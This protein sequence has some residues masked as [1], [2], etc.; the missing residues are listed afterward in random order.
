MSGFLFDDFPDVSEKQWK[1]K[2]QFDLKGLDYNETLFTQTTNGISIKPFYH[3]DSYQQLNDITN[4][5]DFNICQ[6]IFVSDEK[7][8]NYIAI[9]ALKKGANTLLFKANKPFDISLLLKGIEIDTKIQFD[10]QFL[11]DNFIKDL[12]SHSS[13]Y[14]VIL[15]IDPIGNLARTGNWHHSFQKDIDSFSELNKLSNSNTTVCCIHADLYQN[16]G[17][18]IVQQVAYALAHANEY[19]N[20]NPKT[21]NT[22]VNF[23]IGSNYFFE[24]AKIRAFR[25]LWKLITSDAGIKS[26]VHITAF[27]SKYNKTLYDFNTNML[28][29]TSECMSAILGGANTICNLSYDSLYHKS[30]AFGERIARNQLLILKH[31]SNFKK[32]NSATNGSYY[33]ESLTKEI[34][35]KALALFKNIEQNGGFLKQLK[36]GTIQRKI[37]ETAIKKQQQFNTNEI[38]LVGTNIHTNETDNMKGELQLYPFLKTNRVKTL[39]SPILPKR[40]SEAVEQDRL[41]NET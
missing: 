6:S 35:Q 25:Y 12:I 3:L 38:N 9:N 11:A 8:A 2:I 10:L 19:L 33:I 41:K 34:A 23:A 1:Q 21:L 17:A 30:N 39:I 29:T 13:D 37:D 16:A 24:I 4:K 22:N 14:K 20:T 26:E 36:Q 32:T 31:E 7:T 5:I 27:P 18:T 40:L 28:R 15:N